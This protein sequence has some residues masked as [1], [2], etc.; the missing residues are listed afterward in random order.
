MRVAMVSGAN[1][2]I[3]LAVARELGRAGFALSLGVRRPETVPADLASGADVLVCG[4]DARDRASATAWA[5]ST[6]ARFGGVDVLV[7]NAGIAPF[8]GLEDGTDEALDQLFDVNVKGPFRVIQAALPHLKASG[9]GRVVNVASL[10]GKR[11]MGLNVGYQMSKHAVVALTHAVR[12]LG[13]EHGI[14]ATALCPGFVDT[15]LVASVTDVPHDAMTRPE[16]LARIVALVVQLPNSA[17]V[18]ELLVNC[19][20]EHMI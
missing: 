2:G 16:D 7:N 14:R 10:S 20:Y 6:A 11:V 15:D 8:V 13:W 12:R 19:R 9:Q 17:S 1:R 5:D 18:A 3:G 4:Y